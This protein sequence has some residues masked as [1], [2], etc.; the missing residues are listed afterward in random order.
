[1]KKFKLFLCLTVCLFAL[2]GCSILAEQKP[3]DTETAANLEEIAT[4]MVSG[5]FIPSMGNAEL[6]DYLEEMSAEEY[7]LQFE[8]MGIYVEGNA[9]KKG[10]SSWFTATEQLGDSVAVVGQSS[11]YNTKGNAIVVSVL[12]EGNAL[13]S[14]GANRQA[15]VEYVFEDNYYKTISSCA[16]NVSLTTPEKLKNAGLNTLIGMGTVFAVL[17][18]L[19][20]IISCFGVIPKI[21]AKLKNKNSAVAEQPIA[22]IIE[23]EELSD[24]LELVAV[25]TAAIASYEQASAIASSDSF[26]VRSIKRRR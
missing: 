22:Q 5:L 14:E 1:M 2:N 26:V 8:E 25:I 7:E 16:T 18:L 20:L 3:V 21:E 15:V 4:S 17:I 13:N 19:C 11:A 24:D 12:V 6:T 10:I 23:K 9:L